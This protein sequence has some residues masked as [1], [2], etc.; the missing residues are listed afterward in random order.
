MPKQKQGQKKEGVPNLLL[1]AEGW[2]SRH[3]L[4]KFISQKLKLC[5]MDYK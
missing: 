5:Q 3:F 2:I 1:E 4:E